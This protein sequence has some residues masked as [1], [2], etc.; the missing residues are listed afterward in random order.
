MTPVIPNLMFA[1]FIQD[2]LVIHRAEFYS[3]YPVHRIQRIIQGF[4][5]QGKTITVLSQRLIEEDI[6]IIRDTFP[7]INID[8]NIVLRNGRTY[9]VHYTKT[10]D[11]DR[12]LDAA[13]EPRFFPLSGP[14]TT[15][16][17]MRRG[18]ESDAK[19]RLAQMVHSACSDFLRGAGIADADAEE[20]LEQMAFRAGSD[21]L[22]GTGIADADAKEWLE[23]MVFRAASD[24]LAF[25]GKGK[26]AG[27]A[28]T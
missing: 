9:G 8:D 24:S 20:W 19:E 25:A 26:K 3:K 14:G 18:E 2:P 1:R 23:Q 10:V 16:F 4:I 22:R 28:L 12:N 17:R 13:K 5:D 11:G 15:V 21:S 7:Y 6:R 27:A